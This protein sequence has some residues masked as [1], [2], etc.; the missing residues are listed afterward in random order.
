MYC[1]SLSLSAHIYR[2]VFTEA[3]DFPQHFQCAGHERQPQTKPEER[4]PNLNPLKST[5]KLLC[6]Y[7][8]ASAFIS[9]K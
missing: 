2:E 1:R 8:C 7:E 5:H 6:V 9:T 4:K 3:I